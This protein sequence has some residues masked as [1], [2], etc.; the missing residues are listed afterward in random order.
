MTELSPTSS[1]NRA[2]VAWWRGAVIYE[3]HLPSF[4]DGNGD[5]IGDLEG[6][7]DSLD[8]L[9]G[10]LGV[11]AVW[12]GPFFRSPLF[13]QGFD[14]SDY[15][16][17]EPVFGSLDSVDR[18]LEA[19]HARGV[20]VIVDYVPNHTSDQHPWFLESRSSRESPKRDWYVW[21]DAPNNWTSEAGGS[22][23]EWDE[24]TGQFYLHS[25]L[26]EQPD[27]NWRHAGV[28]AAMLDV[29][30]FWLDRG[31][32]GFRIDVAHMLMKDPQLRDNPSS[33][34]GTSNPYDIQH[35][36]FA[37]QLHVNDRMHPDLHG[38]LRDIRGVLDEYPGNRVAIGEI[39]AMDWARWAEFFGPE[40]DQLHLPFAFKL[41]ET[42]WEAD[43]LA[44]V[45]AALDAALP[46]GAWPIFALGN[47]DRPRLATRLGRA[48]ARVAAVLLLTLRGTPSLLYADEL[49]M[50]D[51]DVARDRQ[52]D[53]FGFAPGGVSRDPTRTPMPWNNGPNGGFAPPDAPE[54][55]LPVARDFASINVEAQL[56]EPGSSLNLYR[57]LLEL[58]AASPA[59]RSGTYARPPRAEAGCVT[60]VRAAG[61]ERKLVA[62]NLIGSERVLALTE[63]GILVASTAPGRSGEGVRGE[64]RL[65]PDEGVVVDLR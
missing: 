18:L 20:K 31:V 56:S 34:A 24:P 60:Y 45:A 59:L 63:T 28:R 42:P 14:I 53:R 40:L 54:L 16:D 21:A 57:R 41:I 5:G 58:R 12:V 37:S 8:Y 43:A 17:V 7:I 61:E 1:R 52:R 39:E 29:L 2:D 48:Q 26:A 10:T 44:E 3:N 32:D 51:Q 23:W 38:V 22:V 4:R 9:A 62:L 36:D 50:V 6:L 15:T 49:G 13:D 35:P 33:P 64:L 11:S 65:G 55:W 46:D 30:R 19:A 27:L 47:H 25:H